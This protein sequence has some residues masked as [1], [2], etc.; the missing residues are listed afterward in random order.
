MAVSDPVLLPAM[1]RAQA[2][3]WHTLMDLHERLPGHWT[4]VGGQMVHLHCAE[5]GVHPERPTEDADTVLDVRASHD[6]LARFTGALVD[7]GFG[8]H[9]RRGP[10]AP[11]DPPG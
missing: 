5:R 3:S 9:L 10:A 6:M 1:T 4:L 8:S 7:L 11:V 2:A